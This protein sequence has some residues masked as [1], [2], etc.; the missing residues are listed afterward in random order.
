MQHW[1]T[2]CEG[3]LQQLLLVLLMHKAAAQAM[4]KSQIYFENS[5]D[6]TS[7]AQGPSQA[8]SSFTTTSP[9]WPLLFEGRSMSFLGLKFQ[10]SSLLLGIRVFIAV[11]IFAFAYS[12][13]KT[14]RQ[15]AQVAQN[16]FGVAARR[17]IPAAATAT[18]VA[19]TCAGGCPEC[20]WPCAPTQ[21]NHL[22]VGFSMAWFTSGWRPTDAA[23]SSIT[24]AVDGIRSSCGN[25][26]AHLGF[27]LHEE[28]FGH[29]ACSGDLCASSRTP[30][31][32][33]IRPG[34]PSKERGTRASIARSDLRRVA[35]PRSSVPPNVLRR[36]H[37]RTFCG[38][39][40][41]VRPCCGQCPRAAALAFRS[42]C[43]GRRS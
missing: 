40:H 20:S 28:L 9:A 13:I 25:L 29:D 38:D 24:A 33:Q 5:R 18:A 15:E 34:R 37:W 30:F 26:R 7:V 4:M 11:L 31:R 19:Q 10:T 8:S 17:P 27:H 14:Q 3:V 35:R 42:S 2:R 22:V 6:Q 23:R 36:P 16:P 41:G 43:S 21:Y 12:R 1:C 39:P 32:V